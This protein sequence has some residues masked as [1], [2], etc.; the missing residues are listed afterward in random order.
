M[1][2]ATALLGFNDLGRS[3]T[4]TFL[5]RNR[6]FTIIYTLSKNEQNINVGIKKKITISVHGT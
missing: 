5:F 3:M 6:L 4:P 1:A 2:I